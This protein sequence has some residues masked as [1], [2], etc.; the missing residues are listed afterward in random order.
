[1]DLKC[2]FRGNYLDIKKLFIT[3]T[4]ILFLFFVVNGQEKPQLK[5]NSQSK[6]KIV[7]FTD[8]HI[9]YDSYEN[10]N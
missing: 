5:F 3:F 9:Q 10:C 2:S 6:F 1:M 8:I 4:T 7:Q